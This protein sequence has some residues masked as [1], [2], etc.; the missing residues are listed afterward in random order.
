MGQ[1]TQI[2]LVSDVIHEDKNNISYRVA[3][4]HHCQWGFG[5]PVCMDIISAYMRFSTGADF[6]SW[7]VKN[8]NG[9]LYTPKK[10]VNECLHYRPFMCHNSP[11]EDA[12][13]SKLSRELKPSDYKLTAIQLGSYLM[14]MDNNNGG[15]LLWHVKYMRK[16]TY[17]YEEILKYGCL[18]GP[19]D[20]DH[21]CECLVPGTTYMQLV[22]DKELTTPFI[23]F[24]REAER[25]FDMKLL[26]NQD[27]LES[28]LEELPNA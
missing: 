14:E 24:F 28:L 12:S 11:V 8:N 23:K 21:P 15:A 4:A 5:R 13:I 25:H 17:N 18:F 2:I 6:V 7:S 27:T 26:K 3:T 10:L 19:E 16:G 20:T 9:E 1:R 22:G